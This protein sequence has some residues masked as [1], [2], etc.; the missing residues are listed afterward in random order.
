MSD[1]AEVL[2][3]P[4]PRSRRRHSVQ[5][6]LILSSNIRYR[7]ENSIKYTYQG[8][9]A[10]W[11][12]GGEDVNIY[13]NGVGLINGNSQPWYDGL[14]ANP[15]LQR[16]VLFVVDGLQGGSVSEVDG[17]YILEVTMRAV[18]T[19]RRIGRHPKGLN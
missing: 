17:S 5:V 4:A 15:S 8:A 12:F 9:T 10:M 18:F 6:K 19:R 3:F 14:A 11:R 7:T 2:Q 13:R 1:S 16:P